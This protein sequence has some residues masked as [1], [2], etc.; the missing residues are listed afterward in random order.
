MEALSSGRDLFHKPFLGQFLQEE[1]PVLLILAGEGAPTK[2]MQGPLDGSSSGKGLPGPG[3]P[4]PAPPHP[5]AVLSCCCSRR[6]LCQVGT[7]RLGCVAPVTPV[8][9]D[10][11]NF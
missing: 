8:P 9:V 1:L 5:S 4:S 6:A 3:V 7:G 10:L 2:G 11:L